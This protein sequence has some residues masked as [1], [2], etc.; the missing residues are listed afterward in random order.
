MSEGQPA[1]L[2]VPF[3]AD[4][5]RQEAHVLEEI[6]CVLQCKTVCLALC[7]SQNAVMVML[8]CLS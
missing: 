6:V 4:R 8:K 1:S 5:M 3:T 2:L 7:V